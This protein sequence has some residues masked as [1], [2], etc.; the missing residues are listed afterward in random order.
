[1]DLETRPPDDPPVMEAR[2][3]M[4]AAE[5]VRALLGVT[6]SWPGYP[7]KRHDDA[8]H[9]LDALSTL[10]DF[11]YDILHVADVLSRYPAA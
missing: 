10:A 4:V 11:G 5:P 8:A 2:A 6:A 1:M 9:P 3:E 7:L